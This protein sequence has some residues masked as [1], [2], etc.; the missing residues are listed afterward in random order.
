MNVFNLFRKED[1]EE[2]LDLHIKK[3]GFD[4]QITV[5]GEEC[6]ELAKEV[7]KYKRYRE[8][9]GRL[10]I[11]K[12]NQELYFN[13]VEEFIDVLIM[14]KQLEPFFNESDLVNMFYKKMDK[15]R[16]RVK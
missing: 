16:K 3:Y 6:V 4:K 13:L 11:K 14:L 10:D 5:L 9:I 8:S 15:G 1:F 7:F 12:H 2:L